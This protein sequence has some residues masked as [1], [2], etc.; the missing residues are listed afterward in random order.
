MRSPW[1]EGTEQCANNACSASASDSFDGF[2]SAISA[3]DYLKRNGAK[4]AGHS[5]SS[6]QVLLGPRAAKRERERVSKE[7]WIFV[8]LPASYS[9]YIDRSGDRKVKQGKALV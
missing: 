7:G 6:P 3:W 9:R 5:M 8:R 2:L 1:A 4:M